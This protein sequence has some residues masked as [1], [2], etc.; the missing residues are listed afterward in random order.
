MD[1]GYTW[2]KSI[3]DRMKDDVAK[4]RAPRPE[5]LT[6]RE[7][8]QRF[9]Y[10]RRGARINDHIRSGLEEF[11]LRSNED[12]TV[13]GPDS[14]ITVELESTAA[15]ASP[16]P[17]ASAP[18]HRVSAFLEGKSP[19]ASVKPESPLK[20]AAT[21]M[22]MNHYSRLPVMRNER[23]VSGIVTW[24]SIGT[25]L[26]L[27]LECKYVR[28]CML[29]PAEVIPEN[30]RLFD[31]VDKVAE[32]GYV[33]VRGEKNVIT[34]IVTATDVAR[35]FEKLARPFLLIG[36]I[37]RHLRIL[38]HGKF[39]LDELRAASHQERSVERA[40]D[41][42]FGDYRRLLGNKDNWL[43]LNL[44]VDRAQFIHQLEDAGE[45]RN[46]VMHFNPKVLSDVKRNTI[47]NLARFFDNLARMTSA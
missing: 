45:I 16:A 24:Q 27:G 34:G 37:E 36:E 15:A 30:T 3:A 43:R 44:A 33:L 6:V 8:F 28:Q 9:G 2:L 25:R 17:D 41:L 31:A 12:F 47:R 35:L 1:A 21:I 46:E 40:A 22:Q 23:D 13:A 39:T 10:A 18:T 19:P 11:K 5:H 32:H 26:A 29:Q 38:A 42:T 7:L 20:E 4:G 14:P